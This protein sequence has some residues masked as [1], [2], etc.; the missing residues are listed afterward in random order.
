MGI[1]GLGPGIGTDGWSWKTSVA[2]EWKLADLWIGIFWRRQTL[3][4]D[5]SSTSDLEIWV[6]L[7][8]CLPIRIHFDRQWGGW[9][10]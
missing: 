5:E 8:P 6:C 2:I 10:V 7:I 3:P 4:M 1:H 9:H